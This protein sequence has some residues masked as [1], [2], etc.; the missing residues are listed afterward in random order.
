[1]LYPLSYEGGGAGESVSTP[2]GVFRRPPRAPPTIARSLALR[3]LAINDWRTFFED[4]VF[5]A[6]W[7]RFA[8]MGVQP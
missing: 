5:L 2:A 4:V 1:M 3:L 8:R 6:L 7:R